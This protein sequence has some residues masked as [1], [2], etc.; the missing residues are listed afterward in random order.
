ME[1]ALLKSDWVVTA[2]RYV[3][4]IDIMGFKDL[5]LTTSHDKIYSMMKDIQGAVGWV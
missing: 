1:N 4:Y 5:V 2:D 3:A